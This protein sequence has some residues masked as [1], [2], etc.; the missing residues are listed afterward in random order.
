MTPEGPRREYELSERIAPLNK[1]SIIAQ[2]G[3]K[4]IEDM[5]GR[6]L[7]NLKE[8]VIKV[9]WVPES[10]LELWQIDRYHEARKMRERSPL[11]E[12]SFQKVVS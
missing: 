10:D 11:K 12:I 3:A 6:R 8:D 1:K 7:R 9:T 4:F 2:R 5:S